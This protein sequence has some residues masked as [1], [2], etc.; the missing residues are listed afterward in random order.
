M[1]LAFTQEDCLVASWFGRKWCSVFGSCIMC[2]EDHKDV[3]DVVENLQEQFGE[4][5][6]FLWCH[7]YL[8]FGLRVTPPLGFQ[9]QISLA[10]VLC[11]TD[12]MDSSDSCLLPYHPTSY[13][14]VWQR[15]PL[16]KHRRRVG[17][18]F[19][20]TVYDKNLLLKSFFLKAKT[21]LPHI[22]KGI[23]LNKL[24]AD[25]NFN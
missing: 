2:L 23:F 5:N 7:W 25:I 6:S 4:H 24:D 18:E 12:A 14:S 21:L 22:R 10:C 20:A 13:Q 16:P 19:V 11:R 1:P 17:F 8:C 15:S 3:L 9:S